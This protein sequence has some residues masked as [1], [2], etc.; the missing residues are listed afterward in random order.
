MDQVYHLK[1]LY[2]TDCEDFRALNT[3]TG[4]PVFIQCVKCGLFYLIISLTHVYI[5]CVLW[6]DWKTFASNADDFFKTLRQM[7]FDHV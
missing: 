6:L 2:E 1:I 3:I 7:L 5:I 4:I